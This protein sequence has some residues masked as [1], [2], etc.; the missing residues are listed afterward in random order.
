MY[1]QVFLAW[2]T[3]TDQGEKSR[4]RRDGV[5]GGGGGGKGKGTAPRELGP[6]YVALKTV[7]SGVT[8]SSSRSSDA[9]SGGISKGL[10][11]ELRALQMAGECPHVVSLLDVF[12]EVR[13]CVVLCCIVLCHVV[14]CCIA[15]HCACI[16]HTPPPPASAVFVYT[17]HHTISGRC[18][19]ACPYKFVCYVFL[20]SFVFRDRTLSWSSSTCL[21]TSPR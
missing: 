17:P 4:R 7:A 2:D 12:P 21:P 18:V 11:R 15:S 14:L 20:P 8:S 19:C 9:S 6:G 10:F 3:Q 5:G 1:G 13:H 16:C